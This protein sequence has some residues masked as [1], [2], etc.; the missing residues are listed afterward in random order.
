M[1]VEIPRESPETL[2]QVPHHHRAHHH[3][4]PSIPVGETQGFGVVSIAGKRSSGCYLEVML[5]V[6]KSG[7]KTT[8][9]V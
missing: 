6:Q 3:I 8:W 9:D 7:V 1:I 4:R 5:M 2:T